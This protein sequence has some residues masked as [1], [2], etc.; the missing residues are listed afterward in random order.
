ML[1]ITWV[2]PI[3]SVCQSIVR[4]NTSTNTLCNRRFCFLMTFEREFKCSWPHW[5]IGDP[6]GVTLVKAVLIGCSQLVICG[7]G[8]SNILASTDSVLV[9]HCISAGPL[10]V[11][12]DNTWKQIVKKKKKKKEKWSIIW[13]CKQTLTLWSGIHR[14][15]VSSINYVKRLIKH[16]ASV[17]WLSLSASLESRNFAINQSG[18]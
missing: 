3:L 15:N 16:R 10:P 14:H 17:K 6:A 7:N 1:Y 5:L 12:K 9:V 8:C 4:Q 13:I 2:K 11:V 18:K